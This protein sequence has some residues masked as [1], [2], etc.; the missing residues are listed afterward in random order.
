MRLYGR[1]RIFTDYTEINEGNIERVLSDALVIHQQNAREIDFL[2]WFVRGK[3]SIL[4]R[5][6]KVRKDVCNKTVMNIAQECLD[7]KIGY[8]WGEPIGIVRRAG[9][10]SNHGVEQFNEFLEEQSKNDIDQ[11]LANDFCIGG[12]G[13]RA[14][15]P[16]PDRFEESPF[17]LA[18]LDPETTFCVYS[19]DVFK[20]KMLGVSFCVHADGS[21]TYSAYTDTQRF[22]LVA[23]G[24]LVSG[25]LVETSHNGIGMIP[26]VEYAAPDFTGIYE[27]AIPLL[28]AINVLTS[29]RLDD[30]EQF[31]ASILWIHNADMSDEDLQRL[32]ELLAV[33]TNSSGDGQQAVL[34]YLSTPLDQSSVQALEQSLEEH[35]YELC[36]IPGR[37]QSSGG[38]TGT[39]AELGEAGWKKIEY[40]AKRLEAAWKKGERDMIK[41]ILAIFDCSSSLPSEVMNLRPTDFTIK[42]IRSKNYNVLTKTQ[43]MINM[44]TA[45]IHPRVA[46]RESDLFS[47]PEQVYQDSKEYIERALDRMIGNETKETGDVTNQPKGDGSMNQAI[48]N[49]AA[50]QKQD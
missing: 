4:D 5:T 1:R 14:I 43:G 12:V 42:L 13:Y 20:R 9:S 2:R 25:K 49:K 41:V 38:S 29:N 50:I 48:Q 39:A 31:V 24:P 34:K 44:L 45:G 16:N 35:V 47:D 37:V 3:Q 40:S 21:T 32:D 11:D 28:D 10:E 7:F 23:N 18:K 30:I 8:I 6:K 33:R 36:G 15:L 22:E 17:K 26:I 46:I 27:R 19:N